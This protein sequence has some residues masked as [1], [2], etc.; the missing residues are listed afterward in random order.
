M[1]AGVE[2]PPKGEIVVDLAVVGKDEGALF[3]AGIS[4]WALQHHG[5]RS[6]IAEADDSQPPVTEAHPLVW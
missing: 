5:L 4:A 3:R 2:F 6:L 1:A